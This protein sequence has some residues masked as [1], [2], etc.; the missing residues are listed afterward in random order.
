MAPFERIFLFHQN[1]SKQSKVFLLEMF[2][3]SLDIRGSCFSVSRTRIWCMF[4][5]VDVTS[6]SLSL[7]Y[8]LQTK[9]LWWTQKK[10][11]NLLKKDSKV[12]F[13]STKSQRAIYFLQIN[14]FFHQLYEQVS[15]TGRVEAVN[16]V[17]WLSSVTAVRINCIWWRIRS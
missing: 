14:E 6:V 13:Q 2:S 8:R 7:L 5:A 15:S 17:G 11:M 10:E 3:S 1:I 4:A 9:I 12:V 16:A